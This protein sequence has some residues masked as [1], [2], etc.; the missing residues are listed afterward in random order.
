MHQVR[1][2]VTFKPAHQFLHFLALPALLA[3][4]HG[5]GY[6][7]KI[8]RPHAGTPPGSPTQKF[9]PVEQAIQKPRRMAEQGKV[10]LQV[11]VDS[12]KNHPADAHVFFVR[13]DG[14]VH[15]RQNRLLAELLNRRRQGIAVQTTAAI[16]PS[17]AGY[18][19][20]YLHK[21]G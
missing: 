5:N 1:A 9:G 6:C 14:R 10:L 8:F 4:E 12:P 3:F 13:A 11:N 15:R 18:Q 19:V 20:K 17:S 2:H 21:K 16:H 7:P